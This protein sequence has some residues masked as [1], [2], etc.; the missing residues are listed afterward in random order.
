MHDDA[1]NPTRCVGAIYTIICDQAASSTEPP[2]ENRLEIMDAMHG[3]LYALLRISLSEGRA[4][5]LKKLPGILP[6]AA[7]FSL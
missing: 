1:A 7:N 5:L 3:Q 4:S 6:S 2:H